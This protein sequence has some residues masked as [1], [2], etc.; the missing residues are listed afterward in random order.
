MTQP[1]QSPE[2]ARIAELAAGILL[3][4]KALH[5]NAEKPFIFTS[6]WASPVY[7]DC[8]RIISFPRARAALMDFAVDQVNRRAGYEAFDAVAGG[9]TAGI[10]FAAWMSERM[11]LP[12]L[13]IRK[14]PKGFGR[15]A[16][17]EGTFED[18]ARVLLVEDLATDAASKINFIT[19]LRDAGAKV[20]EA[21]VIFHYGIF[22]Q[23]VE[24]MDKA[25]ARLHALCTWWDVLKVARTKPYFDEATLNEVEKFLHDPVSWSAAH[26]G[27]SSF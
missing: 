17:I 3:D 11:N 4:I 1:V 22:P 9:E 5:F 23:S 26:G 8:R 18:G 27:K 14:K 6:G 19:A 2:D 20:T 16:Q 25:G 13:Y 15:N 21:F 7:T 10:P 24:N 12:M